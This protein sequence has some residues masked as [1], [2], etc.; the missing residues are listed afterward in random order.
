[1]A[2]RDVLENHEQRRPST[3]I[4]ADVFATS[5]IEV[6]GGQVSFSQNGKVATGIS[7][8][9]SLVSVTGRSD[10]LA[11]VESPNDC[12]GRSTDQIAS[13]QDPKRELTPALDDPHTGYRG[14]SSR[15]DDVDL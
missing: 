7:S 2:R 13:L 1:M 5:R 8:R 9:R 3:G 6:A 15:R 4:T 10:P 14:S 11:R 12:A